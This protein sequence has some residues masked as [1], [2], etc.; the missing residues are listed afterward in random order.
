[1]RGMGR[2]RVLLV[3]LKLVKKCP[4][5][6]ARGPL[7]VPRRVFPTPLPAMP[8]RVN[9]DA[10]FRA[11]SVLISNPRMLS[12]GWLAAA[13]EESQQ[14]I[15]IEMWIGQLMSISSA[16]IS[17]QNAKSM[18]V[19]STIRR[20]C[21]KIDLCGVRALTEPDS[22]LFQSG[23]SSTKQKRTTRYYCIRQEF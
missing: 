23:K 17:A 1:V 11:R 6:S 3:P 19:C 21:S 20:E 15:R 4:R 9:R 16:L 5:F 12:A 7:Y 2:A 14:A 8:L 18:S 13:S 10:G 22:T